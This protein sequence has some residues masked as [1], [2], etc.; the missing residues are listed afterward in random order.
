MHVE[1]FE[2]PKFRNFLKVEQIFMHPLYD[3][4][5]ID[6]DFTLVKLANPV[7][8]NDHV[9]PVC[10]PREEDDLVTSFPPGKVSAKCPQLLS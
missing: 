2:Q 8:L 5:L 1:K 3:A 9:A 4:T 10:F 7:E 6:F